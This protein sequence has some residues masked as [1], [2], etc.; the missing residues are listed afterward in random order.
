[1]V[2]KIAPD[3]WRHFFAGILMGAILQAFLLYLLIDHPL[4]AVFIAFILVA[5]ISYGFEL[6]SKIT[7]KGHY[8][9]IDAVASVIG[10]IL[11]M[12]VT[13]LLVY[14]NQLTLLLK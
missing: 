10:G 4:I 6:F 9:F 12:A 5:G 7:G 11:G 2:K 8:D 13:F 1:M 14:P 3:K